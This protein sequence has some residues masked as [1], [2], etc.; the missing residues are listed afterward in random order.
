LTLLQNVLDVG[1]GSARVDF[2]LPRLGGAAVGIAG[3]ATTAFATGPRTLAATVTTIAAVAAIALGHSRFLRLL[4]R[5]PR[6][7]GVEGVPV[8]VGIR[9]LV[10]VGLEKVGC[11]QEGAF[12]QA[13]VDEGRLDAGQD[14]FNPSFVN[15][16]Y[17]TPVV[18]PVHQQFD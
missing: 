6:I 4:G 11:V 2:P 13:Y 14:C 12:L 17:G 1:K 16:A 5:E 15:V 3:P 9:L 10:L 18:G 7:G 8:V